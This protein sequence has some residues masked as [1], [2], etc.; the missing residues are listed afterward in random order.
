[1]SGEHPYFAAVRERGPAW[2]ASRPMRGQDG[3][4]AH[5]EFMDGLADEGVVVAGGPLGAGERTFLIVFDAADENTVRV[6]LAKDP[7]TA[8]DLLRIRSIDT[9]EILLGAVRR[10]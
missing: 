5:A 4:P 9:W 8:A 6:R 7:W 2:D 3:W 10:A 1:M